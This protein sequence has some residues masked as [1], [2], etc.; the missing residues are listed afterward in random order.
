MLSDKVTKHILA[1]VKNYGRNIDSD[2]LDVWEFDL[3]RYSE[4]QIVKA[5]ARYRTDRNNDR[6]PTIGQIIALIEG[7]YDDGRPTAD[8]AWGIVCKVMGDESATAI[9]TEEMGGPMGLAASVWPDEVGARRTF[10]DSY[11]R[12]VSNARQARL[13]VKWWVSRGNDAQQRDDVIRQGMMD[14]RL[15]SD[16]E[17]HLLTA[18]AAPSNAKQITTSFSAEQQ[19]EKNRKRVAELRDILA[20]KMTAA[21]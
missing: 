19:R 14:G 21:F 12:A 4:D 11:N 10:I 7:T 8:E 15:S 6:A 16:Y 17:P 2:V 3:E 5:L 13:P 1:T 20:G 9:L 18:S